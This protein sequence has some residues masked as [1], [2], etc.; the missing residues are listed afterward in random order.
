MEGKL[1]QKTVFVPIPHS[2]RMHYGSRY[3]VLRALVDAR[4]YV[5]GW[6]SSAGVSA[7]VLVALTGMTPSAVRCC[8]GRLS[9]WGFVYGEPASRQ[10]YYGDSW[11]RGACLYDYAII[12]RGRHY[13]WRVAKC[14]PGDMAIWDAEMAAWRAELSEHIPF[15]GDLD[16][17][18]L[19][20]YMAMDAGRIPIGE[21]VRTITVSATRTQNKASEPPPASQY[22]LL[23]LQKA[24]YDYN[25]AK[26]EL[27]AA[28]RYGA[29][30]RSAQELRDFIEHLKAW[31]SGKG[32]DI[33]DLASTDPLEVNKRFRQ[34]WEKSLPGPKAPG[35]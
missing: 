11:P 21:T 27:D 30:K 7:W 14:H 13:L 3:K 20:E 19:F 31:W 28:T 4:S 29:T 35:Y 32:V 5:P 9:R 8:L 6:C 34:V 25:Q 17:D 24:V 12:Q 22:S 1:I 26:I 23:D 18:K 33:A 10:E 15:R 16:T 2:A